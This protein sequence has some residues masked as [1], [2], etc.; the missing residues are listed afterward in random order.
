MLQQ[1]SQSE[2]SADTTSSAAT[3]SSEYVPRHRSSQH[4]EELESMHAG[5]GEIKNVVP[6]FATTETFT[7]WEAFEKAFQTYKRKY[8]LKFRVRSSEKTEN[9][10]KIHEDQFP[11]EFEFAHRIYRCTHGVTQK[12][13]SKGQRNRKQRYCKCKARLTPTVALADDG[14]H[15]IVIRNQN[16]THSH[17]TTDAQASSYLTTA[18]IPLDTEDREDVKTLVDARVSSS[19]ISNFLNER[20]GCK[21][22]PQQTRNLIRS[23]MGQDSAEAMLKNMLHSLRQLEG[24]DVL[25]IQDQLDTTCGIVIQTKVQKMMFENWGENLT[26]DFTHGTNNLGY[27]LGS[28]VVT[29]CTGRG[30][31]VLDFVCLNETALT[32]K[33]VLDYFKEKNPSWE[34]VKTLVIDK[35]F[36]EWKVLEECFPGVMGLHKTLTV[37][38]RLEF[39][40]SCLGVRTHQDYMPTTPGAHV[41]LCQFHAISYWKKVMKRPVYRIKVAES[42]DLLNIMMKMLYWYTQDSYEARYE[43]LKSYCKQAKKLSFL[44][45][46]E[47][48]WNNCR[49]MWSNYA[50][51][52]H[53]TAGNTTTNRIESNWKYLKMLLGG[54]TRIDKTI[55]GL[56]QHQMT[57]ARQIVAEIGQLHST[58]RAP[59]VV[60]KFLRAVARRLSTHVLDKVKKEWEKFVNQLEDTTCKQ[61]SS[62]PEWKVY[63]SHYEY[64]CDDICWTC[65]CLFYTSNHLPCCHLMHVA[66]QGHGFKTLPGMSIAERWSI[67][68]ALDLKD[69]LTSAADDLQP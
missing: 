64:K 50:R 16:H 6:P 38:N 9:Y 68:E 36:V 60:P 32:M 51:G 29:T 33:R 34:S 4:L 48:N 45:Y 1:A 40:V 24:S 53:F 55:A 5:D 31:P 14:S 27:H 47:K 17:P 56:L 13:R 62:L 3:G 58:M 46:F 10:N 43:D 65:T 7:S 67:F 22:T 63:S 23:I 30:F 39:K 57:I 2:L 69:D 21:V 59:A 18:T 42:E 61:G 25:V 11:T 28:L 49:T 44:A 66:S 8:N 19:H 20:I 41:L 26:M 37:V 52:R 15:G 35:D 12:S 54:K